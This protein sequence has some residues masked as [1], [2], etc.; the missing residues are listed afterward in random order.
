MADLI[1]IDPAHALILFYSTG[2]L[3]IA[4][5]LYAYHGWF[6]SLN[7]QRRSKNYWSYCPSKRAS[8]RCVT[9]KIGP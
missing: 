9:S 8:G 3:V 7:S 2:F 5:A 1:Q 4:L 6:I